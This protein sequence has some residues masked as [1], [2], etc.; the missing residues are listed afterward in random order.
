MAIK[1]FDDGSMLEDSDRVEDLSKLLSAVN[2]SRGSDQ[3]KLAVYLI[4]MENRSGNQGWRDYQVERMNRNLEDG[5]IEDGLKR[6]FDQELDKVLN[7]EYPE[8]NGVDRFDESGFTVDDIDT[9]NPQPVLEY[10]EKDIK[11]LS[12]QENSANRISSFIMY[13]G[14]E[15]AITDIADR[16]EI[17]RQNIHYF[18]EDWLDR[19]L[20]KKNGQDYST[21]CK[22]EEYAQFLENILNY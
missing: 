15:E 3:N 21:T 2:N 16:L 17:S 8:I 5:D 9:I 12:P 7:G 1:E 19:D 13:A 10:L 6:N 4:S 11:A 22:G 20:V 14:H 18:R